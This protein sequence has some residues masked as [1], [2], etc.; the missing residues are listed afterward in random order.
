MIVRV[1]VKTKVKFKTLIKMFD[2]LLSKL[3]SFGLQ[4]TL[5]PTKQRNRIM[6][7]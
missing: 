2:N 4:S 1:I 7:N 5:A 3:F 6:D